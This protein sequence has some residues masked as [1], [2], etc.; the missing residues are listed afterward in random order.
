MT[1]IK[2]FNKMPVNEGCS[3]FSQWRLPPAP[4]KIVE[5]EKQSSWGFDGDVPVFPKNPPPQSAC[6]CA[7]NAKP[8][9]LETNKICPVHRGDNCT[10]VVSAL[11]ISTSLQKNELDTLKDLANA[12]Q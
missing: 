10:L 7:E 8:G 2:Q 9:V 1:D 3:L 12:N 11:I 5:S 6:I 4:K